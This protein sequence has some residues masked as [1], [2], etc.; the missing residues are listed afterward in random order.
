MEMNRRVL[1]SINIINRRKER[2][3]KKDYNDD[4]EWKEIKLISCTENRTKS[5][6]S[7]H[8]IISAPPLFSRNETLDWLGF[9]SNIFLPSARVRWW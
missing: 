6:S 3:K 9:F 2:E 1:L 8:S 5:K 7:E 4:N